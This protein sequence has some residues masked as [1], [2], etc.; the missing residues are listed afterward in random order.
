MNTDI[1]G[2]HTCIACQT[3]RRTNNLR[4]DPNTFLA[5]CKHAEICNAQHP[6]S[7]VNIIQRGDA[8]P[9]LTL[10]EAEKLYKEKLLIE[11]PDPEAVVQI[12]K[13]LE[14]PISLRLNNP[15]LAKYL[16]NVKKNYGFDSLADT[17]R[18]ILI[19][20]MENA[21]KFQDTKEDIVKEHTNQQEVTKQLEEAKQEEEKVLVPDLEDDEEWEV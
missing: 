11:H 16:V 6:N 4:Y 8:I 14:H 18:Y 13:L 20:S 15:D 3:P 12:R 19:T 5:Y 2:K 1:L 7:P 10:S 21:S 9:L 17:L